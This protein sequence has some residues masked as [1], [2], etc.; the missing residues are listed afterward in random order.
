MDC[1]V[2]GALAIGFGLRVPK[3]FMPNEYLA[4]RMT[5]DFPIR[6]HDLPVYAAFHA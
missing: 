1:L 5:R 4:F 3:G 2:K 6:E